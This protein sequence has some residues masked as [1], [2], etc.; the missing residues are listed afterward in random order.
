[1]FKLG[2]VIYYLVIGKFFLFNMT[3]HSRHFL[4]FHIQFIFHFHIKFE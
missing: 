4:L 1:V 3:F 2:G